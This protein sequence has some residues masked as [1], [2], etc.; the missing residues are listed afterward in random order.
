[1]MASEDRTPGAVNHGYN[2][3]EQWKRAFELDPPFVMVTGWNE[4]IAG[5]FGEPGEPDR[6]R[7]SVQRGVQPRHRADEGRPRRQLL[8][9]ARRQRP[10]IQRRPP[11]PAGFASRRPSTS[12]AASTNGT[13]SKPSSATLSA[14]PPRA[15][16][17]GVGG[18][19]YTDHTGRNDL[20]AD[21]GGARQQNVYFYARTA[22]RITP[23]TDPNWMWLLI[24]ADGDPGKRLGRL[25]LTSSTAR[26]MTTASTWLEKCEAAGVGKS[27]RRCDY[28]VAA[29]NCNSPSPRRAGPE[30]RTKGFLAIS[31]GPT[32]SS[33][34]A[35]SWTSTSAATSR[36]RDGLNFDMSREIRIT[37]KSILNMTRSL[38]LLFR[39]RRIC[40]DA[41]PE[42]R[43]VRQD[44]RRGT[45]ELPAHFQAPAEVAG[46]SPD[47][48]ASERRRPHLSKAP[49]SC[50]GECSERRWPS[51]QPRRSRS[52]RP[53]GRRGSRRNSSHNSSRTSWSNTP[54]ATRS[55]SSRSSPFNI[56][57]RTA[58]PYFSC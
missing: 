21:E 46:R 29:M 36:R 45:S 35:T 48:D 55:S 43:S 17:D 18:L 5:R 47:C 41:S 58:T 11:L 3:A 9:P 27:S 31:N 56:V 8:L 49:A 2:F 1:M 32:T 28:R 14:T 34:P 38:G 30:G 6:L 16:H 25:R 57:I 4:W 12:T 13:T 24:D 22:N 39:R 23:P 37:R 42:V 51:R 50:P 20:V 19:H 52:R 7:R 10:A 33:T 15:T 54:G 40:R 53:D 44:P 26:S